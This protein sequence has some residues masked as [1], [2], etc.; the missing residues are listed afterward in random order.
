MNRNTLA[1]FFRRAVIAALPLAAGCGSGPPNNGGGWIVD[2]GLGDMNCVDKCSIPG[3]PSTG[4]CSEQKNSAGQPVTMC[5]PDHTGRRPEGLSPAEVDGSSL[6]AHFARMAHLE[7]A[8]VPAFRQLRAELRSFG[9]PKRLLD[10]CSQAARDEIR[11]AR[12]TARL[13]RR[14]GSRAPR[15]RLTPVAPRSLAQLAAENAREGCVRESFGALMATWQ[16]QRAGDDEVRQ[17]MVRIAADETRHAELAWRIHQWLLTRLDGAER[18]ATER[19]LFDALAQLNSGGVRVH[20]DSAAIQA[21]GL[22][23]SAATRALA[24][25]FTAETKRRA[26]EALPRAA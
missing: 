13:A 1:V 5:T 23:P 25:A 19:V 11:H 4:F 7:A 24:R 6:G 9:A 20:G 12:A 22:P 3:G 10:A 17:L 26:R 21:L 15:V 18:L 14:F 8:S 16:A 2:G